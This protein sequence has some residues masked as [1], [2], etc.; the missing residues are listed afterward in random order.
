M[1]VGSVLQTLRH[2]LEERDNELQDYR[3]KYN[4]R[5]RGEEDRSPT[6]QDTTK[7]AGVLVAQG[8]S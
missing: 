7:K 1:Q 2:K 3:E 8:D 6:G 5:I 4:I